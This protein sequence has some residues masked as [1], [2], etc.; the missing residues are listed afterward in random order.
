M[1]L[2]AFWWLLAA[3]VI[4]QGWFLV[5][6][7][8]L[9]GR[10]KRV[11]PLSRPALVLLGASGLAGLAYGAAQRDPVFALGQICLMIL[12]YLMQTRSHDQRS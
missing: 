10:G 7:C 8:I 1:R 3:T 5:R 4:P 11:Q 9:R 12:Y 2:P 6:A